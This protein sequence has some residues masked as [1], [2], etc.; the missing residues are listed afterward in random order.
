MAHV[1]SKGIEEGKAGQEEERAKRFCEHQE[2]QEVEQNKG[3]RSSNS[4]QSRKSNTKSPKQSCKTFFT[5]K[6]NFRVKQVSA[7]SDPQK[8]RF[9]GD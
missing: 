4:Q 6:T 8:R 3:T 7:R 2:D 1:G 5:T 9:S